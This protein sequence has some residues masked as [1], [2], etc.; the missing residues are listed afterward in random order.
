MGT[1]G[2][3]LEKKQAISRLSLRVAVARYELEEAIFNKTPL[4]LCSSQCREIAICKLG[5]TA[6]RN[7]HVSELTNEVRSFLRL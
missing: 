5:I 2:S 3:T 7:N 6:L 1:S 4:G